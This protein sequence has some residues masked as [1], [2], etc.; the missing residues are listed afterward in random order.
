MTKDSEQSPA[1]VDTALPHPKQNFVSRG[2]I[3]SRSGKNVS[4][5][6]YPLSEKYI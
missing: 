5:P 1:A 2:H 4:P 6:G 3:T